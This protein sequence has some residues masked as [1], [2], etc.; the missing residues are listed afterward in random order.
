MISK[1]K[2]VAFRQHYKHQFLFLHKYKKCHIRNSRDHFLNTTA[3]NGKMTK[4][5]KMAAPDHVTFLGET[6]NS[7]FLVSFGRP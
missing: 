6:K 2:K 4:I 7:T 3:A 5:R 1:N